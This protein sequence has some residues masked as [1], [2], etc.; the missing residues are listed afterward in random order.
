MPEKIILGVVASCVMAVV[1]VF[2]VDV[3]VDD[4]ANEHWS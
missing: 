4:D 1:V 2:D 3:D